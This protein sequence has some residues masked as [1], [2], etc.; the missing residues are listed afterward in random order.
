MDPSDTQE[1]RFFLEL[2][3]VPRPSGHM[4]RI[5][6]YLADFATEHGLEHEK[7]AAGNVLIRRAGNGRTIVLQGHQD[8]VPNSVREFDFVSCSLETV[9]ED[10]WIHADGT[11]LGADDGGGLAL[12]LCALVDP[13]LDGISIE[14]L[15]TTDEEV[16][17]I[18]AS[19][20]A[21]GW[22]K[23]RTMINIDSEDVDEI[24]IGSAG[25]TDIDARFVPETG[26]SDE[27]MYELTVSGLLGGHSAGIIGSGRANAILI[28]S[29]Y[30]RSLPNVRIAS[31][32]AGKASNVIPTSCT[33]R[34]SCDII[35]EKD[36]GSK[37]AGMCERFKDADP[38][39]EFRLEP[40]DPCETSWTAEFTG[41][42]L[43]S[44]LSCPNGSLEEDRY[45][46]KTSS[47]I[48]IIDGDA[49][50][51]AIVIKPRSSDWDALTGLI[52]RIERCFSSAGAEASHS[53][54]FPP[55]KEPEDSD[56]VRTA[57][58]VYRKV[59]GREPRIVSVH[60][61]LESS[62]IKEKHPGMQAISIGPTILGA[63]TPDERMDLSTLTEMKEYLFELVLAL[64]GRERRSCR[65]APEPFRCSRR[66]TTCCS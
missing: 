44:I 62:T 57:S 66:R 52:E 19:K 34:F 64:C 15:F 39:I 24:T 5:N 9:V 54:T 8:I 35:P 18:G 38:G 45:G 47:N 61:G 11:T 33:A 7:D 50:H 14:C 28:V 59:F 43:D 29:E 40:C 41:S 31:I 56:L 13:K 17:L 3:K 22:L 42:V 4:E 46:V 21:P 2:T 12:M 58:D 6:A 25:S 37:A 10:G 30:L 20:M 32:E 23:G 16:G 26:Q 36:F 55:W 48:G 49:E 1:A 65:D 63:H 53:E 51:L 27:R 60:G